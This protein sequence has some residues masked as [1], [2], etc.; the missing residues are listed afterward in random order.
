MTAFPPAPPTPITLI[1]QG[2]NV[3]EEDELIRGA[4]LEEV[5]RVE[6][7]EEVFDG[8]DLELEAERA[9]REWILDGDFKPRG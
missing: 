5:V 4:A 9:V 8:I 1:L 2:D 6:V 7:D 3:A